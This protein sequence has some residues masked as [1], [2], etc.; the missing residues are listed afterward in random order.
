MITNEINS[1]V[2]RS[3]PWLDRLAISVSF[4]CLA[5][6]LLLPVL[7]VLLPS[8]GATFF[9]SESMHAWLVYLALPISL[10]A[11][12][13]GCRQHRKGLILIFGMVGLAILIL[14][15]FVEPLG[16]DHELET[17]FTVTGALFIAFAHLRNFLQCKKV[18]NCH[19]D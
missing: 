2:I 19:C 11:L 5:H 4:L 7:L 8:L 14:G 18:N 1:A 17:V 12:S 9:A 13:M 16:L 6:C 15:I 10:F 3:T